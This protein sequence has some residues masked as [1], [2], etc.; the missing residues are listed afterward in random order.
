[1][2]VLPDLRK[3]RSSLNLQAKIGTNN[4][5]MLALMG[6]IN[7]LISLMAANGALSGAGDLKQFPTY[8]PG[9]DG[10]QDPLA[11]LRGQ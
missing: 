5:I 8:L 11:G 2:G 1:L 4:E 3:R 9:L 6:R 10:N 7:H